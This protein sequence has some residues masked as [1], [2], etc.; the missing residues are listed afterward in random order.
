MI[1]VIDRQMDMQVI[2]E[3]SNGHEAVES[4]LAAL[5]DIGLLDL[6]MPI[7]DG[8]EAVRAIRREVPGARLVVL[9][10]YQTEED[11]YRALRVGAQGYLFKCCTKVEL[12]ECIR[13]VRCGR[14]W[15]PPDVGAKLAKRVVAPDLTRRETDVLG[16]LSTGR[17]NKEIG[18]LFDIS[19]AT[20]KVHMTHIL[21]KLHVSSRTEAINAAAGRGLVRL[22]DRPLH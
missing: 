11:I 3:A 15:I 18:T 22:E 17:S 20:V 21:E 16:A 13:A 5:P 2:A 9:T 7:V 8:I 4:F 1:A 14:S 12:L 19:E 10:S 6:R